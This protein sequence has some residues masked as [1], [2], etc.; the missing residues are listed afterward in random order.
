MGK[1]KKKKKKKPIMAKKKKTAF[2]CGG[3]TC[4]DHAK[5]DKGSTTLLHLDEKEPS[6]RPLF[7]EAQCTGA[8]FTFSSTCSV[9]GQA[10]RFKISHTAGQGYSSS[11][12]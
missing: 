11:R 2:D 12:V 10:L 1:K 3:L 4:E 9:G 7:Q 5:G 8:G 6:R